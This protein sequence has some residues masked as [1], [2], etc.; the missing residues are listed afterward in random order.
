MEVGSLALPIV[1]YGLDTRLFDVVP[2]TETLFCRLYRH[3]I[4]GIDWDKYAH[5]FFV[6]VHFFRG[7]Q[8]ICL[9]TSYQNCLL[10]L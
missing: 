1:S 4:L 8:S 6:H 5:S 3:I 2:N 10:N 7:W 9:N